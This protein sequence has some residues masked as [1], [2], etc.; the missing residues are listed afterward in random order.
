MKLAGSILILLLIVG[1]PA[2]LASGIFRNWENS[3]APVVDQPPVVR[4]KHPRLAKFVR[5]PKRV[6]N[7]LDDWNLKLHTQPVIVVN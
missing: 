5:L 3:E 2:S 1:S 7:K 4:C 6:L